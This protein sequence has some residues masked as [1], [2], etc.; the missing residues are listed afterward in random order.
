[1]EM[2]T[3][4]WSVS[5]LQMQMCAHLTRRSTG[6]PC[7]IIRVYWMECVMIHFRAHFLA[8]L[9]DGGTLLSIYLVN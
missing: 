1:M 7:I 4:W 5:Y 8:H 6:L 9:T 3:F 2:P